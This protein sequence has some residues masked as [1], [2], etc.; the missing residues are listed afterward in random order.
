MAVFSPGQRISRILC[1]RSGLHP[2]GRLPFP[3]GGG[4]L[5]GRHLSVPLGAAY[6]G[7]L[8]DEQPSL[9]KECIPAWPCSRWGLPGRGHCCPRRWSLTPP[10]HPYSRRSGILS[11]ARSGRLLRPGSYPA[12]CSVECGLSS[13]S[14]GRDHP[15]NLGLKSYHER[16]FSDRDEDSTPQGWTK[17]GISY[18][19][20]I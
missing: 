11:V 3:V 6:L 1:P 20:T 5:S 12:S 8:E 2:S 15:A 10:F 14:R 7:L 13:P 4:H 18:K 9:P 16:P 17:R 19:M